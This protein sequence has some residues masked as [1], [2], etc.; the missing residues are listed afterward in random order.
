M[1]KSKQKGSGTGNRDSAVFKIAG[2]RKPKIKSVNTNLKKLNFKNKQKTEESNKIFDSVQKAIT[3]TTK[4]AKE[5][6][7]KQST[8]SRKPL[9]DME[10]TAKQF[11]QL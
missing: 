9:P 1:G 11:A 3:E 6:Q 5:A 8:S 4:P 7:K 2:V 10:E